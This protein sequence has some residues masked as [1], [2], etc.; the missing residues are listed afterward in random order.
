[1]VILS[2]DGV[3]LSDVIQFS[4]HNKESFVSQIDSEN[5]KT[6]EERIGDFKILLYE[7]GD[8]ISFEI[9]TDSNVIVIYSND[10]YDVCKE[11]IQNLVEK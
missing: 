3:R 9:T 1:M 7:S 11:F 2:S 5:G 10:S 8:D 4:Q 6:K